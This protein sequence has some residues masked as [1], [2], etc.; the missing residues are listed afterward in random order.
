MHATLEVFR[1]AQALAAHAAAR[2]GAIA[3]NIAHADTPGYRP[4][5]VAPFDP[6]AALRSAPPDTAGLPRHLARAVADRAAAVAGRAARAAAAAAPPPPRVPEPRLVAAPGTT[7][8]NG[9]AV[10]LEAEMM[11]AAEARGRHDLA[12]AIYQSAAGLIRATVAR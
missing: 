5:D 10:S 12:L 1:T 8:P 2:H 9:N 11:K 3:R 7:A 4:R 6:G